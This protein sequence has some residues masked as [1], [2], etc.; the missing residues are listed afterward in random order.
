MAA[1]RFAGISLRS[2]RVGPQ[3]L[4][5]VVMAASSWRIQPTLPTGA[6]VGW[7]SLRVDGWTQSGGLPVLLNA[8]G[9]SIEE[10][11]L[12]DCAYPVFNPSGIAVPGGRLWSW[13]PSRPS[14]APPT[15]LLVLGRAFI[16]VG[17]HRDPLQATVLKW[18]SSFSLVVAAVFDIGAGKVPV[19]RA[20]RPLFHCDRT[21]PCNVDSHSM[22]DARLSVAAK[23]GAA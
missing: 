3:F 9:Q 11:A 1:N 20:T 10:C 18:S 15:S 13:P 6:L 23:A 14:S 19:L 5:L 12:Y 22:M 4:S 21:R 2:A 16:G 7:E 17:H 8:S